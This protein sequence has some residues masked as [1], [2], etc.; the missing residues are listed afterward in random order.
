[1]PSEES[2]CDALIAQMF[3]KEAIVRFGRR[4]KR[5][6]GTKGVPD[7]AYFVG[8]KFIFWEVKANRDRLS[9]DQSRFLFRILDAGGYAGCGDAQDLL[10]YLNRRETSPTLIEKWS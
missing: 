3:G 10:A 2:R 5:T 7:R 4:G 9:A 1:M 8:N 6:T